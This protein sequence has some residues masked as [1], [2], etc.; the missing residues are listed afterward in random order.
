[1]AVLLLIASGVT[2]QDSTQVNVQQKGKYAFILYAGGG[3]F[4]YSGAVG[5]PALGSTTS[6]VHS[7]P[8]GT[9]R[10]M[11]HPDHRLRVGL[12]TGYTNFYTYTA[13]ENNTVGKVNLTAIPVLLVWSMA[14]TTRLNIFAGAGV[15]LLTTNLDYK[16][17]VASKSVSQG[18]NISVNYVQP[19]SRK[20]G[21]A[22]EIKWTDAA[23]TRDYGWSGQLLLV[24][25]MHEW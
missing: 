11:W 2:A 3:W 18:L 23:Q 13:K 17:T 20:L 1:M 24:W 8:I 25:K 9:M 6:I 19:L 12:E 21:L 14:L 10:I 4:Y 5:S 22:A 15:Y 16:G 7:H